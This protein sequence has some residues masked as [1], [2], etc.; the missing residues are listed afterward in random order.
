MQTKTNAPAIINILVRTPAELVEHFFETAKRPN[1]RKARENDLADFTAYCHTEP[2]EWIE[3]PTAADAVAF[4]LSN[5]NGTA[6]AAVDS[7]KADMLQERKQAPATTNRRLSTLRKLVAEAKR[8][9]VAGCDWTLDVSNARNEA[10]RNTEGPGFDRSRRCGST[11]RRSKAHEAHAT[12]SFCASHT[13]TH[14]GATASQ[15]STWRA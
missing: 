10:Y 11:P 4:L 12:V 3:Q 13:T 7:Y 1:T 2:C 15:T 5:G 8:L 6:N 9:S 14:C